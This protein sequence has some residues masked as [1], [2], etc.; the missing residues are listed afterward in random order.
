MEQ[1]E[2]SM[3]AQKVESS[4]PPKEQGIYLEGL[5]QYKDIV[6]KL[7]N[8]LADLVQEGYMTETVA[9]RIIDEFSYDAF[10]QAVK[11]EYR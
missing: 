11:V 3:N 5:E 6:G 2:N 4:S 7:R 8:K 10:K 9:I 1:M